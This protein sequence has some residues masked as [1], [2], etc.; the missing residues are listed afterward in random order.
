MPELSRAMVKLG[1]RL[2]ALGIGLRNRQRPKYG[3]R[4]MLTGIKG[5]RGMKNVSRYRSLHPSLDHAT[6]WPGERKSL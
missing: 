3:R 1:Y 4:W 5:I 6:A 2:W